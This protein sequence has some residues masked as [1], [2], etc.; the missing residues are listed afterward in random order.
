MHVSGAA[1]LVKRMPNISDF[2][3]NRRNSFSAGLLS[4]LCSICEKNKDYISAEGKK[5]LMSVRQFG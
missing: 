1:G 4:S 3:I 2:F 5:L